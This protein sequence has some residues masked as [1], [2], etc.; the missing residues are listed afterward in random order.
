MA[1]IV[2]CVC[3][4]F[5]SL[6]AFALLMPEEASHWFVKILGQQR[7]VSGF[8]TLV[9]GRCASLSSGWNVTVHGFA[10]VAYGRRAI[11]SR[12]RNVTVHE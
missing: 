4:F 12:G 2:M 8:A 7:V 5:G 3:T 6:V 1:S 11:S 10:T 9:L